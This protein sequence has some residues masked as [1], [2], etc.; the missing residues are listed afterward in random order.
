MM[1]YQ[2][3]GQLDFCD[4]IPAPFIISTIR[5]SLLLQYSNSKYHPKQRSSLIFAARINRYSNST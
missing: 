5:A 1:Y 3:L 2:G 4:A